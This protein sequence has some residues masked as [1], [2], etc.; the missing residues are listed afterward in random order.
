[1][2]SLHDGP[3]I[4]TS[5][6]VTVAFPFSTIR[7]GDTAQDGLLAEMAAVLDSVASQVA[8]LHPGK[9]T[10]ELAARAHALARRL[11]ADVPSAAR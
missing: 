4:E 5:S 6:R 3:P 9:E 11:D 2:T 10:D 8:A 7:I 1:M